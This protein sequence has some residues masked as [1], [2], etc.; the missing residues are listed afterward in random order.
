MN[1]LTKKIAGLFTACLFILAF[2][3]KPPVDNFSGTW[4]LNEGKSDLGQ[5]A[6]IVP[7]KMKVDQNADSITIVKN[8]IGFNGE[9]VEHKETLSFDGKEKESAVSPGSSTRKASAKW[10][11]DGKSLIIDWKLMLDFNGQTAEIK[12]TETWTLAADGTPLTVESSSS[13][14]FGDNKFKAYYEK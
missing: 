12:G 1:F 11:S 2:T 5:F 4:N 14:S 10:S 8:S 7:K 9:D 3:T 6:N 13:S